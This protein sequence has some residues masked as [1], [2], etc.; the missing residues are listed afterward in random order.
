MKFLA[1]LI[2]IGLLFTPPVAHATNFKKLLASVKPLSV[3]EGDITGNICTVTG[4][5]KSKHYWLTA[6]HCVSEPDT[7]YIEGEHVHVEMLDVPNDLAIL[8]T[9]TLTVP[10]LKLA[11]NGPRMGDFVAVLGFPFGWNDHV[12]SPGVVMNPKIQP[13]PD[14]PEEDWRHY[15]MLISNQGAPGNSGSSVLNARDEIVGVVQIG[16]GRSWSVLGASPYD[17]L[18]KYKQYWE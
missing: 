10:A 5:N 8:S 14:A 16:W 13:W 11:K 9:D 1:A 2:A 4:I 18:A 12:Y 17:E 7:Y 3:A 15:W 6:A